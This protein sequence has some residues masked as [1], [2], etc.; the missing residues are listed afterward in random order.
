[1]IADQGSES[2]WFRDALKDKGIRPLHPE[3]IAGA[4]QVAALGSRLNQAHHMMVAAIATA[5]AKL[6]ASLS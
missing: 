6:M 5:E 4:C 2:C 3:S 1:M